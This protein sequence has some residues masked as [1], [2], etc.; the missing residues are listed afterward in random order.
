MLYPSFVYGENGLD[1]FRAGLPY[2]LLGLHT[3]NR[4]AFAR[5]VNGEKWVS[6]H[7]QVQGLCLTG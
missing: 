2:D 5:F 4:D 1:G 6:W 7:Q 3:P